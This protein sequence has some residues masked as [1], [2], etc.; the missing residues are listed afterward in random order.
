MQQHHSSLVGRDNDVNVVAEA[1]RSTGPAQTLLITGTAGVGK[2]AVLERARRVAARDG[3]KVLR[4]A[5]ESAEGE[6]GVSALAD[7]VCRVLTRIPDGRLPVR[8]TEIRRA[9]LRTAGRDGDLTLLSTMGRVLADAAHHV[10]FALVLDGIERMPPPTAAALGLMLRAFRPAGMPVVMARRSLAPARGRPG[11]PAAADRVLDLA[12][13]EPGDVQALVEQRLGRPADPEVAQAVMRSL[14]P[15]AGNPEAVLSVLGALEE[16]AGLLELDRWVHLAGPEGGLRLAGTATEVCR[17][18]WPGLLS[19]PEELVQA[20]RLAHLIGAAE[21]R[22]SDLLGM[23][24][25]APQCYP[26]AART[27]DRLVTDGVLAVGPAGR[28]SFAVPAFAAALRTSPI[29]PEVPAV[30]AGIALSA[31]GRLSPATAGANYPRLAEHVLAAGALVDGEVAVPLLLAAGRAYA[32]HSAD[33]A[34]RAYLAA[35]R[36]LPRQHPGRAQVLRAAAELGLLNADHAAIL[37]LGEPLSACVD[38][39]HPAGGADGEALGACADAQHPAVGADVEIAARA[40]GLAALYEHLP[41]GA[42]GAQPWS[43]VRRM[44]AGPELAALAGRYEIGPVAPGAVAPGPDRDASARGDA[45]APGGSLGDGSRGGGVAGVGLAAVGPGGVGVA[46]DS[47]RGVDAADAGPGVEPGRVAAAGVGTGGVGS[48]VGS[49]GGAVAGDRSRGGGVAGGGPVGLG[50]LGPGADGVGPAGDGLDGLDVLSAVLREGAPGAGL[51]ASAAQLRL[52]AA[53]GGSRAGREA[54]RRDLPPGALSDAALD[55]V[56]GAAAYGDLAGALACVFGD[57][58]PTFGDSFAT[59]YHAMVREYLAGNWAEALSCARRIEARRQ[60]RGMPGAGLMARVLAAEIHCASGEPDRAQV[61]MRQVPDTLVHPLAARVRLSVRY[62]SGQADEAFEGGWRDLRRARES[63][64]LE[65]LERFLLRLLRYATYDDVPQV[66]QRAV[67][68]LEALHEESA[69]SRT[70]EAVLIARAETQRDLDSALKALRLVQER[71]DRPLELMCLE[72]VA[73]ASDDPEPWLSAAIRG[74]HALGIR[75]VDRTVLSNRAR[76][77]GLK[78]PQPRRRPARERASELD[79]R[80]VAMVGDG[81]T[82][83]QI[84]VRLACSEKTVEQRLTRLFRLTGCH[85]RAELA[86]AR[87]D[88]SLA[89]LGLLPATATRW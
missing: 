32:R 40:W 75:Y 66:I 59:R 41:P 39:Q 18:A 62:L 16:D 52:L 28:V 2:T 78:L 4:L 25:W 86:A 54:A 84:A 81:A 46:G 35:L 74:A 49:R 51:L 11:L 60:A 82:N 53:A 68:E 3:A 44:P 63:G 67:A 72:V 65:G 31:V 89:R 26:A 30:H 42:D 23:T 13:L 9:E 38:A 1:L 12:P 29:P 69:S 21:L 85:S 5:W 8:I 77:Y 15:L 24:R 45:A 22:L 27:V 36:Y 20:V 48:G 17:I 34:V 73:M 87:L 80:L 33:R 37:A 76:K 58:Y 14:G 57:R 64:L 61:W 43:A 71:G 83:R 50:E 19:E 10:P 88:G 70:G 79:L 47:P 7:A 55:R 56:G 6:P